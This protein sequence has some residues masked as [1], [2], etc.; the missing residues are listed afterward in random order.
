MFLRYALL[1]TFLL[2]FTSHAHA[3]PIMGRGVICDSA[4]QV[5]TY[6]TLKGGDAAV[7]TINAKEP[8]ACAVMLVAFEKGQVVK[9]IDNREITEILVVAWNDGQVWHDLIPATQYTVFVI[10]GENV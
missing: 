4:A 10:A 3:H 5:E 9:T 8:K 7:E 1:S 2:I 6:I